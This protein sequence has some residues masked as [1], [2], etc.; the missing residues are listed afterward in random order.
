MAEP[1]IFAPRPDK[2]SRCCAEHVKLTAESLAL[3]W[4]GYAPGTKL[5][6][7]P[8]MDVLPES[9]GDT[10]YAVFTFA[11]IHWTGGRTGTRSGI[12]RRNRALSRRC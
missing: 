5:Q 4:L 1:V 10:G 7:L 9:N 12:L 2:A 3:S 11:F 6:L 8:G